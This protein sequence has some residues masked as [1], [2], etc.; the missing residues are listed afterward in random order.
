MGGMV[1]GIGYRK[2]SESV[3]KN[4][5]RTTGVQKVQP[6][7]A[8]AQTRKLKLVLYTPVRQ[9]FFPIASFAGWGEKTPHWTP[10][11][12]AVSG[13]A[14]LNLICLRKRLTC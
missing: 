6:L 8:S 4:D 10:E 9:Q 11:L 2:T 1:N 14:F 13:C 12:S 3:G 7:V 5:R